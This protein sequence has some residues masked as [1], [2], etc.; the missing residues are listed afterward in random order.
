M[1]KNIP[2]VEK[3]ISFAA[4]KETYDGFVPYEEALAK[5]SPEEPAHKSTRMISGSSCTRAAQRANPK[6]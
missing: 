6:V 2:T 4:G 5:A 3:Y 1:K